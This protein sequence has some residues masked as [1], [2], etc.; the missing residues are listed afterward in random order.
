MKIL[1]LTNTPSQYIVNFFN[2]L[3]EFYDLT[4]LLER[5][6]SIERDKSWRSYNFTFFNCTFLKGMDVVVEKALSLEVVKYL[7]R[8]KYN[9][10]VVSN[11]SNPSGISSIEYMR[12]NKIS[13]SLES[14]V[15]FPK[16]NNGVKEEFKKHIIKG[17]K[18][19]FSTVKI[20]GEYYIKYGANLRI[21]E[22]LK[23]QKIPKKISKSSKIQKYTIEK[24]DIIHINIPSYMRIKK[25]VS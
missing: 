16:T 22:L 21:T 15:G 18:L 3:G 2:E 23:D 25:N 24:K 5:G 12:L 20:H 11:F 9:H 17:A 1:W 4:V 19:Y 14:D 6:E 10:I 8:G 13:N 7:K